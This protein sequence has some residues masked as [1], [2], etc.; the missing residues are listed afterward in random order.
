VIGGKVNSVY[1]LVFQQDY[2]KMVTSVASLVKERC[3]RLLSLSPRA[4]L[5]VL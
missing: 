2:G 5:I 3:S 4:V 1:N